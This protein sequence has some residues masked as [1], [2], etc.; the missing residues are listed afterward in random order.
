MIIYLPSGDT[1]CALPNAGAWGV[2]CYTSTITK[3]NPNTVLYTIFV[4][5]IIIVKTTAYGSSYQVDH[6][7]GLLCS[8]FERAFAARYIF[9]E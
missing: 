9:A 5:A 6:I 8:A 4:F 1:G 3:P 7:S 2:K